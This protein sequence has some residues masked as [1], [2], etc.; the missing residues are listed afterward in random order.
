M[1]R[2]TTRPRTGTRAIAR[3]ALANGGGRAVAVCAAAIQVAW[4]TRCLGLAQYGVIAATSILGIVNLVTAGIGARIGN[5]L[6][7]TLVGDEPDAS[8]R[9]RRLFVGTWSILVAAC[10]TLAAL[11]V[12]GES[13]FPWERLLNTADPALR[14]SAERGFVLSLAL[15][16]A[17]MPFAL[18][19]YGF[20]AYQETE[21]MAVHTAGIALGSL[22]L[23]IASTRLR[24]PLPFVMAAPFL[25]TLLV[26]ATMFVLFTA[27]RRWFVSFR[28][29]GN[30]L[31]AA[32]A[33]ARG[34]AA[35]AAIGAGYSVLAYPMPYLVSLAHG[36]EAA[37]AIDIHLKL[38]SLILTAQSECLQPLWPAYLHRRSDRRWTVRALVSSAGVSL[39]GIVAGGL[40][41][42]RTAPAVV[43]WLTGLDVRLSAGAFT[44]LAVYAAAYGVVQ[45]VGTYLNAS[46][47]LGV[48]AVS[49]TVGLVL[50]GPLAF[51]LAGGNDVDGLVWALAISVVVVAL[52]LI[53]GA[54]RAVRERSRPASARE[55]EAA[56]TR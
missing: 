32:A 55:A 15:Q 6:T 48:Q 41:L 35:F 8:A 39:A 20:R 11:A 26:T 27:R 52:G 25:A 5:E 54:R 10:W 51:G 34:A 23:C 13:W 56:V 12:F 50:L 21:F 33:H 36:F 14:R 49:V 24:D 3:G 44:A 31:P 1:L 40:I 46:G 42:F 28:G 22:G 47:V 18:A 19:A 43:P 2:P 45:A 30:P 29:L 53:V 38:F 37:G 16:L 7:A 9:N 4:I 17:A